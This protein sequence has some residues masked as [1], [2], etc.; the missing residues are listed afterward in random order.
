MA[1]YKTHES[2]E[3]QEAGKETDEILDLR[4]PPLKGRGK[5]GGRGEEGAECGQEPDSCGVQAYE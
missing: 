5:G 3:Q 4:E 2:G 1:P